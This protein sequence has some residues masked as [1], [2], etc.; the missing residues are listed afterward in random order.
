MA[1]VTVPQLS[2][3]YAYLVIDD[4]SKECGVVDCAEA[5]KV[6]SAAKSHGAKIVAVLTTH[7]HG[8]HSGGNNDIAMNLT[9]ASLPLTFQ[10]KDLTRV[11]AGNLNPDLDLPDIQQ[12]IA[13]IRG[14]N[15][16]PVN[17]GWY[18]EGYGLEA[19]D[20]DGVASHNSYVSHHNGAQY[21]GYISNTPAVSASM[22]G[23]TDF[24]A[25]ATI[26]RGWA[27]AEQGHNEAGIAQIHEGLAAIRTTGA[28]L[29]RPYFLSLLAEVCMET[30]RP[31]DGL[32]ALREALVAAY[33]HE[34]RN[35]EAE[36]YRLKGELLL[37]QNGSNTAEAQSCLERAIVIA[38]TQGVKSLELRA[39]M[40][41]AR[42]LARK[43]VATKPARSSPIYTIGSPRA[44]T[45][46]I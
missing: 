21:F 5:D 30:G 29:A 37:R 2:D 25:Y 38:R 35:Y 36:L 41:L 46:P 40:S 34:N 4:G 33:E 15:T 8:D 16:K 18:Q 11:M 14:L 10:G 19:T 13:Y 6:I 44:S 23:L 43:A 3:N 26:M 31:D 20:N 27:M 45:L 22:H 9:F 1:I 24:F 7:W 12:D 39:T 32:G 42:L 17:W 28:E